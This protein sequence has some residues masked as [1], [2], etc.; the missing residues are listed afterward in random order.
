MQYGFLSFRK[1]FSTRTSCSSRSKPH[2]LPRPLPP[3]S[4][5]SY[6]RSASWSCFS[7]LGLASHSPLAS[8]PLK[9]S[10][11]WTHLAVSSSSCCRNATVTPSV[12]KTPSSTRS[13]CTTR[14]LCWT[15]CLWTLTISFLSPV[16]PQR[17]EV[18]P[19]WF[20]NSKQAE[21]WHNLSFTRTQCP[22]SFYAHKFKEA[23]NFPRK[24]KSGAPRPPGC[25]YTLRSLFSKF[26]VFLKDF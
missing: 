4:P 2:P 9:R 13:W 10:L 14:P 5:I 8:S 12:S 17:P 22:Y 1:S 11:A 7:C 15:L 25:S 6:L 18:W 19:G 21:H 16:L 20:L 26:R 3:L 24:P 23:N